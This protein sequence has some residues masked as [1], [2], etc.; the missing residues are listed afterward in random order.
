MLIICEGEQQR[1][2]S[3]LTSWTKEQK[4]EIV[5]NKDN[6]C[7][8]AVLEITLLFKEGLRCWGQGIIDMLHTQG[9]WQD[10]TAS[11]WHVSPPQ[12]PPPSTTQ[13]PPRCAH[14]YRQ[15]FRQLQ[16]DKEK[17]VFT[18]NASATNNEEYAN[19][20]SDHTGRHARWWQ[21]AVSTLYSVLLGGCD[22][23]KVRGQG[24]LQQLVWTDAQTLLGLIFPLLL[25]VW[26]DHGS[27]RSA[28]MVPSCILT[29]T[30]TEC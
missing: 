25:H 11:L 20:P 8:A 13:P 2:W 19:Q 6:L 1:D 26:C 28:Y 9:W 15:I 30:I 17:R 16:P 22:T 18:A 5:A 21:L 7:D 23:Q 29:K 12:P 14:H 4:T 27:I 24:Q 10:L 3:K